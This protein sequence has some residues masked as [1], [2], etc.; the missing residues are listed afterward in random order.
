MRD[1]F[2]FYR[3]FYESMKKLPDADRLALYD[4][5]ADYALN[6]TKP[7]LDPLHEALFVLMQAQIDANNK[8]YEDGKKGGRSRKPSNTLQTLS[9]EG[10]EGS[11]KTSGFESENQWFPNQKPNVNVN[12]N[13]N[14]NVKGNGSTGVDVWSLSHSVLSYLNSKAGTNHKTNEVE[15]V[16]LISEL[17]HRGYTET[18]MRHVIDVKVSDWRGD[19]KV[20]QYLRPSTLFGAK[21]EQYLAQPK[22]PDVIRA[23]KKQERSER[24]KER[25]KALQSELTIVKDN[26]TEAD[27]ATRIRLRE[28]E[29]WLEDEIKRLTS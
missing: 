5:L 9:R 11:K 17:S 14:A 28:R 24:D 10:F 19:P 21:F 20:E 15:S 7:E 12:A 3:S 1:S 4:A 25:A 23:E 27:T 8:R 6:E 13:E 16:R 2:V 26:I 18:D 22:P 29:A